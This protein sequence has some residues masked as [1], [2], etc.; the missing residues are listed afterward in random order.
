MIVCYYVDIGAFNK[1]FMPMC[2][3]HH[4]VLNVFIW[5]FGAVFELHVNSSLSDW[6]QP[7]CRVTSHRAMTM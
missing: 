6:L 4:P 2:N 5:S 3:V 1:T 7:H